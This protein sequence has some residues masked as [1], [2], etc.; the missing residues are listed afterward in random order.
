VIVPASPIVPRNEDRCVL[1]ISQRLAIDRI[2]ALALTYFVDDGGNPGGPACVTVRPRVIG[3]LSRRDDP[4]HVLEFAGTDVG[5]HICWYKVDIVLPFQTGALGVSV[6][7][8]TDFPNPVWCSP[9]AVGA[10][11]V[12]FPPEFR[13]VIVKQRGHGVM[14]KAHRTKG[15]IDQV[16]FVRC[17]LGR[18]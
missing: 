8:L 4:D 18:N 3:V 17:A 6:V 10:G 9:D 2:R 7:G 12:V 1:P 5:Q 11:C 16:E 13:S 14:R 15:I